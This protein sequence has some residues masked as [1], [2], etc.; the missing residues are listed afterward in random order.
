MK[1]NINGIEV[2]GTPSEVAELIASM[3]TKDS[4]VQP[5]TVHPDLQALREK[6]IQHTHVE[7]PLTQ[8]QQYVRALYRYRP[9]KHSSSGKGPYVVEL[10][11]SGQQYTIRQLCRLANADQSL[12]SRAIR[13]AAD[14]GSVI[15]VSS[16]TTT[17]LTLNTR[18]RLVSIGT[19]EQAQ[20]ARLSS[21][22]TLSK[23]A[24]KS[25]VRKS[26]PPQFSEQTTK[27]L[28]EEQDRSMDSQQAA[29][30]RLLEKN[31]EQ[32]S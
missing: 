17:K 12:V 30:L 26:N 1:V 29:I 23:S 2:E 18:V 24:V 13:R 7:E 5:N 8:E 10:L 15:E 16:A 22:K 9:N 14:G 4:S 28:K 27:I 11:T 6:N 20:A 25:Y 3:S 31:K 21:D 32:N 19:I